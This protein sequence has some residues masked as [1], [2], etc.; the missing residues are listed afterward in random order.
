V[1]A[2]F[3]SGRDRVCL[4][5][6]PDESWGILRNGE[7]VCAYGPHRTAECISTFV[8]MGGFEASVLGMGMAMEC[9][10]VSA[11]VH[12]RRVSLGRAGAASPSRG[13]YRFN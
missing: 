7:A 6:Y 9:G 8:R 3:L 13:D 5:V 4:V 10:E 12:P 1:V 2:D 11:A